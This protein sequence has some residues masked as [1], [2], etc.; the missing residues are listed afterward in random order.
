MYINILVGD[1]SQMKG[2]CTL[3]RMVSELMGYPP[4]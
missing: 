4:G 1:D 3:T 2:D